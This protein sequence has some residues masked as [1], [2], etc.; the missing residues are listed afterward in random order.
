MPNHLKNPMKACKGLT[1]VQLMLALFALGVVLWA[2]M[3]LFAD[4]RC[5]T[6]PSETLCASR[7]ATWR[8]L[9]G[10]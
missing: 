6:E 1:I 7:S 8:A 2:A 9:T 3:N 4:S 5:E 10:K